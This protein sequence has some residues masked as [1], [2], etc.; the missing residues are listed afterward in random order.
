MRVI[1]RPTLR[2]FAE[3]RKGYKDH[4]VPKAALDAW[5][6]AVKQVRWPSAADVKRSCAAASIASADR[7]MFNIKGNDYRLVV[8]ADFDKAIV[9]IKWIGTYRD[10]DKIDV[11]VGRGSLFCLWQDNP[12]KCRPE[13]YPAESL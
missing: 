10:Y 6:D 7:I 12:H 4:A 11:K 9:R 3:R 1:S 5:F 13:L 8:A 2:E